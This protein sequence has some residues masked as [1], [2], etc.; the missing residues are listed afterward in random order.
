MVQP[1]WRSYDVNLILAKNVSL[2]SPVL[3][4]IALLFHEE[5]PIRFLG[6]REKVAKIGQWAVGKRLA[7][8]VGRSV[9]RSLLPLSLPS[10]RSPPNRHKSSIARGRGP[11]AAGPARATALLG[12]GDR[13]GRLGRPRSCVI[14]SKLG[15]SSLME[16]KCLTLV[17]APACP[18]D[19]SNR[20]CR[21]L[22]YG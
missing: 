18:R 15:I 8:P 20:L 2:Q 22:A 1:F 19:R 10:F 11:A 5:L 13:A 14:I 3:W 16:E 21:P 17:T 7:S 12:E 9:R 6:S 4:A